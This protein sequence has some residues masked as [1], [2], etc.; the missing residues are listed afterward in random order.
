[1]SQLHP[2]DLAAVKCASYVRQRAESKEQRLRAS[3]L[4]KDAK[5]A[6]LKA[7]AYALRFEAN[8]CSAKAIELRTGAAA[9]KKELTDLFRDASTQL[10]SRLPAEYG[11]WGII[12]TRAYMKLLALLSAQSKRESPNLILTTEALV[13]M[14]DHATWTDATF[15]KLAAIKGMPKDLSQSQRTS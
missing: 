6:T 2:G 4:R 10:V 8:K 3:L 5:A 11:S 9:A 1:M 14:R 12:K 15:S 7:D 13:L